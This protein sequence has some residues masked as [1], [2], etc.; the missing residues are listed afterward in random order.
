MRKKPDN[1]CCRVI[2][3]KPLTDTAL[4]D[5]AQIAKA[6]GDPLRL[7]ILRLIAAQKAPMCACDIVNRYG[8]SQSTISHHLKLL[9]QAGLVHAERSGLWSYFEISPNGSLFLKTLFKATETNS[10]QTASV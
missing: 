10:K 3:P 4:A 6:L 7:D 5:A 9:T 8:K 1:T 2:E